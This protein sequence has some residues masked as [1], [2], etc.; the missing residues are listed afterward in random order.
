MEGGS[1]SKPKPKK[2]EESDD[3]ICVVEEKITDK[4]RRRAEQRKHLIEK[5]KEQRRREQRALALK[6]AG[7]KTVI[8]VNSPQ[9]KQLLRKIVAT[10]SVPSSVVKTPPKKLFSRP[11]DDDEEKGLTCPICFSSFWYPNQT[12]EHM[13]TAHSFDKGKP[14]PSKSKDMKPKL[15]NAK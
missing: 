7:P 13:K 1:R 8:K 6:N 9:G 11:D 4:T 14:S 15:K 12:E 5:K 3:E 10:G 2:K